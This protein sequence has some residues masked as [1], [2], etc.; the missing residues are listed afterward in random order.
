MTAVEKRLTAL[1]KQ[2]RSLSKLIR[3]GVTEKE[4]LWLK[5]MDAAHTLNLSPDT[6]R[7]KIR[8]AQADPQGSPYK[9]GI[10]WDGDKTYKVNV[11]RWHTAI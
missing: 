2:V 10:H 1:E 7:R 9:K 6:I 11:S 3:S 8:E 5:V 4:D